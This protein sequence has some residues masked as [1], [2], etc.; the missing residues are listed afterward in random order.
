MELTFRSYLAEDLEQM[1]AM[2]NEILEDGNAFPGDELLTQ[3]TFPEMLR[4]Q[5]AVNCMLL[6]QKLVGFYILHPNNIGRCGHVA[7]A[8]Y[9]LDK[10]VRGM[11]LGRHLVSHC[12]DAAKKEGFRGL[13]FN[14][15]VASNL[16]A[17]H[18][19]QELGFQTVGTIPG[20]YRLKDGTYSD[21]FILYL[22]LIDEC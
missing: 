12:L 16:P 10:S 7:N 11:H 5:T 17:L 9:A 3:E 2:W 13:Q 20:G 8:S 19:Y 21:M 22:P 14:A 18:I 6:D 1:R 4:Q 15:V